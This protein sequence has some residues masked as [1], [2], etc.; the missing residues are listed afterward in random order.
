M[1]EDEISACE[2]AKI[3]QDTPVDVV[4]EKLPESINT[5]NADVR[6]VISG[7]EIVLVYLTSLKFY[8]A[9]YYTRKVQGQWL[10]TENISSQIMSDGD[11]YPTALS[12][13]GKELYLVKQTPNQNDL[14]VSYFKNLRWTPAVLLNENINT[15]NDESSAAISS[16]GRFL[17]FASNRKGG[18]GGFDIYRSERSI[19]GVWE[20]AENLGKIINTK[21]DEVS[22]SIT[23][24]GKVLYFSSKGHYNMGGFDIFY[25]EI[26]QGK[27]GVPVN[28]GYPV[29]TTNIDI[30][31]KVVGDGKTAYFSRQ[32]EKK[33]GSA[34]IYKIEVRS[35]FK[36]KEQEKT[37]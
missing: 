3:I 6:P 15:P 19:N 17:Y 24:N 26:E 21:E 20:R 8:N 36:A 11:F 22:P 9:V 35:K 13:D 18:R 7:D 32:M 5:P 37:N 33:T 23:E 28:I 29:N 1:L 16:D 4:W 34:D 12:Y 2:R 31:L 10:P 25:S 14:Y 27:W 30:D